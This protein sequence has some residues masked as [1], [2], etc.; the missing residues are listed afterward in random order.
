MNTSKQQR[1]DPL[2]KFNESLAQ[3][4]EEDDMEKQE[5]AGGV[6]DIVKRMEEVRDKDF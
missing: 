3:A 5:A 4:T 1:A 6:K 2:K